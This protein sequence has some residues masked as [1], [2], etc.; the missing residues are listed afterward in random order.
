MSDDAE[1]E[2]Q[3]AAARM[4]V[5]NM[6]LPEVINSLRNAIAKI[7]DDPDAQVVVLVS[8][9]RDG[10]VYSTT[11]RGGAMAMMADAAEKIALELQQHVGPVQ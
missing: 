5:Y 3:R 8:M 2:R 1:L 6:M 9:G 7:V 11:S 10:V 4:Y